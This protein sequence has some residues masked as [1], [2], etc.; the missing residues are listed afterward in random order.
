VPY[1]QRAA[2]FLHGLRPA[3]ALWL[4]PHRGR[5]DEAGHHQ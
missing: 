2:D 4:M 1:A 3:T 5:Y